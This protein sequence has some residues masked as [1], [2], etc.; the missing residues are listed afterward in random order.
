MCPQPQVWK[1]YLQRKRIEQDRRAE[2]EFIGMVSPPWPTQGFLLPH[3][4]PLHPVPE[5]TVAERQTLG[6][7]EALG[8]GNHWV[9]QP[10]PTASQ[11]WGWGQKKNGPEHPCPY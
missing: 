8:Q 1:G 3:L 4:H 2:M 9:S 6:E 11:L 5:S 10:V 7:K